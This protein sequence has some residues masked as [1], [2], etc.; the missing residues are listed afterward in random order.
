[1]NAIAALH[2]AVFSRIEALAP[3]VLPTLARLIFAGTLLTYYV[4]AGL[5]KFGDGIGGLVSPSSGAYVQIFPK[6]FESVGYDAS[7]LGTFHYL[8]AL[9]GTWGEVILPVLVVLGLFTRIAAL[10]MIAVVVVQSWVDIFGHGIGAADIGAWFDKLPTALI[11]DQRAFW[12][13]LLAFLV[14]RGAG[15]VSVDR[16]LAQRRA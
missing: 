14:F 12:L 9:A 15:P 4:G 5:S 2:H 3:V 1:M 13:F 7:Q 11:V 6:A 8:V 10:G 16:W